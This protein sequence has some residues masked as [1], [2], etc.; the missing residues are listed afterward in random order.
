MSTIS[1]PIKSPEQA[2]ANTAELLGV[3][4]ELRTQLAGYADA[5]DRV[6]NAPMVSWVEPGK[7]WLPHWLAF[8]ASRYFVSAIFTRYLYRCADAL[9]SGVM[10]RDV[11][12]GAPG[13]H[14]GDL[15]M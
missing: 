15:E 2:L 8:P 9:K 1:I 4:P 10:R 6:N 3:T 13:E 7:P 5:L 14:N 11:V 12:S